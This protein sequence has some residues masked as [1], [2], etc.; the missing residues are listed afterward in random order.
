MADDDLGFLVELRRDDA[1]MARGHAQ[2]VLG[3]PLGALR[4]LAD[5]LARRPDAPPLAVGEVVTTGRLT[6]AY[7]AA[8]G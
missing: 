4:F 5:D 2:V 1:P 8:A 3:G 6:G 7:E